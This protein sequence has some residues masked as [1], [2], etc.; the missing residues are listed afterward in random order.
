MG[1]KIL[2]SWSGMRKYLE[3][4]MLAESMKGRIRYRC[5]TFPDMDGCGLFEVFLDG[6]T[7]KQFSWETVQSY[8]IKTGVLGKNIPHP[9]SSFDYWTD[10]WDNLQEIPIAER[11]EYTDDEFSEALQ[12]YRNSDIAESLAA[13]NPIQNMFAV[14]DRRVGKRTLI[15]IKDEMSK[16][17]EW[18]DRLYGERCKAEGVK[19]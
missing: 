17:P 2:G 16:M 19:E 9:W 13:D 18:L 12:A 11:T 3:Q 15:K 14:L 5:T 6:K 4:E 7:Y 8:F 1:G 10:C